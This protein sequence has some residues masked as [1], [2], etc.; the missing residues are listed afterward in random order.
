MEELRSPHVK[1]TLIG[2]NFRFILKNILP[3]LQS[4]SPL[5]VL[6]HGSQHMPYRTHK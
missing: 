2:G 1:I 4:C 5:L 3:H 6:D